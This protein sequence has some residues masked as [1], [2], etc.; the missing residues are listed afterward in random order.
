MN[1]SENHKFFAWRLNHEN[2]N[3]NKQDVLDYPEQYLG[4]NYK[5]LLNY[6]FYLKSMSNEQWKKYNERLSELPSQ[7]RLDAYKIAKE[8]ASEVVDTKC[9]EYF[10]DEEWEI[11]A[12]HLYLERGIPFTF[13]H[14]I[15][16]L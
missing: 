2:Y 9:L 6:W 10:C 5:E 13:L 8:L 3:I 16:D 4:P 14:L 11:I 12:A 1:Y 15:F 7:T